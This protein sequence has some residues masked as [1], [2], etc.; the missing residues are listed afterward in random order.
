MV[1]QTSSPDPMNAD[2]HFRL[3]KSLEVRLNEIS[4]QNMI[5]KSQLIRMIIV[6][7]LP[8]YSPTRF[9]KEIQYENQSSND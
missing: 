8:D 9:K 4:S 5:K 2:F 6:N 7:H 1:T 3:P